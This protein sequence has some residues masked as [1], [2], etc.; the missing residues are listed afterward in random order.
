MARVRRGARRVRRVKRVRFRRRCKRRFWRSAR[1]GM[2]VRSLLAGRVYRCW[3][4]TT[5]KDTHQV[6]KDYC[7]S[8]Q[9]RLGDFE[10]LMD[11]AKTF[12]YWR[13][14][15]FVV[16]ICSKVRV[17]TSDFSLGPW[18]SYYKKTEGQPIQFEDI[19]TLP[20]AKIH[21]GYKSVCRRFVPKITKKKATK[22]QQ[23]DAADP[24]KGR[25]ERVMWRS[26][27]E[28]EFTTSDDYKISFAMVYYNAGNEYGNI[29]I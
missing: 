14:L 24:V 15:K 3:G 29:H 6:M 28:Y 11:D 5:L 25:I 8:L 1:R 18:H 10:R 9:F 27:M 23:V 2:L 13:I 26:K 21:S 20:R 4:L 19:A 16:H 7:S 17:N 12:N 22:V